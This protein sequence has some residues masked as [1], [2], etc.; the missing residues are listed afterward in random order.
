MKVKFREKCDNIQNRSNA[1]LSNPDAILFAVNP[2]PQGKN[3][4][5]WETTVSHVKDIP[6]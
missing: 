1:A 4:G 6:R 5:P 3:Q 2:F